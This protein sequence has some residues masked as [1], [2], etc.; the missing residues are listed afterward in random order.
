MNKA[1][2]IYDLSLV[3]TTVRNVFP[4]YGRLSFDF[5]ELYRKDIQ[6]ILDIEDEKEFHAL[7]KD[8]LGSLND[9]HTKYFPP[10][11]YADKTTFVKPEMPSHDYSDGIL[12]IKIN[13]FLRDHTEYVKE[14]LRKY[15]NASLV[16]LDI[17]N[18]IGGNTYYGAK[19][20][21]LFISG[22]FHGCQKWTQYYKAN[23]FAVATK[24]ANMSEETIQRYIQDGLMSEDSYRDDL[25]YLNHTKY[26]EYVDTYGS[27]EH[28]ALYD[29]PVELLIGKGTMSAAEDFTAMFK[30]S[31]RALLIGSPTN[32]ST[33]S[34]FLL[35]L[36]CGGRA[37]V[38]SV[39]Y[40]LLDGTEFIGKGIQPDKSE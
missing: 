36:K 19:I 33:G 12:T 40:R 22:V 2:M 32:G 28:K 11:R 18:N 29:G 16:R 31:R 20:A 38:V 21:E 24:I 9:G 1:D 17:R 35:H 25:N 34:P 39:G 5:D 4:Y 26:E 6:R 15:E 30:S 23:D 8:F 3:W 37:Q 13:D 14:C 7:L 10:E 27:K